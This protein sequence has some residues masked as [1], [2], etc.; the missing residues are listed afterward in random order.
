MQSSSSLNDE[1]GKL[2][3]KTAYEMIKDEEACVTSDYMQYIHDSP[4]MA[5]LRHYV[6]NIIT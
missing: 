5:T 2:S 1:L 4:Q 6:K 3:A